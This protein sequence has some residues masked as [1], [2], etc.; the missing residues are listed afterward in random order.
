M[1]DKEHVIERNASKK[2]IMLY[3]HQHCL[4]CCYYKVVCLAF[5]TLAFW[6]TYA[7]APQ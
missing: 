2:I 1:N 4:E 5:D 6:S 3:R 7:F